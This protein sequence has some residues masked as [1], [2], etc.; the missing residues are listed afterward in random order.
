MANFCTKCGKPLDECVCG[1]KTGN[2]FLGDLKN[3]LGAGGTTS[4]NTPLYESGMQIVPDN[5]APDEGEIPI[6]Q[7]NI[8]TLKNRFLGITISK[9]KGR[10]QVTN[11]RVVFRAAGRC[12]RGRTTI[13]Q[14]FSID[15]IAGMNV[16]REYA[17]TFW[18]IIIGLFIWLFGVALSTGMS[19]AAPSGKGFISF[20]LFIFG[21]AFLVPFFLLKDKYGAKLFATGVSCGFFAAR[22]ALSNFINGTTNKAFYA[23]LFV[24]VGISLAALAFYAVK[25]NLVLTIKTK[26][27]SEAIDIQRMKKSVFSSSKEEHTGY[28]E[29][30]PDENAEK[31]IEEICAIVSDIQKLGDFGMEKWK[32]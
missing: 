12:L 14:E 28:S 24:A 25:P 23:F 22:S 15:E 19:M 3:K 32:E 5:I 11:K 4:D 17:F 21:A 8:A 18:D 2:D 9:A 10:L 30:L 20:I 13:Q 27:S 31:A 7:Y 1:T 16:R 6:K 26:S 29:V